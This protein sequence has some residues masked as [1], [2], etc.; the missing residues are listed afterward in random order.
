M[1][2]NSWTLISLFPLYLT[3]IW[4]TLS[5]LRSLDMSVWLNERFLLGCSFS[6]ETHFWETVVQPLLFCFWLE[7]LF[8]NY[9]LIEFEHRGSWWIME[10][11]FCVCILT[12]LIDL[13]I[14]TSY[15]IQI[16]SFTF[17]S[18]THFLLK[19]ISSLRRRALP[20]YFCIGFIAAWWHFSC[21]AQRRLNYAGI[22]GS[23]N[24][25]AFEKLL[26]LLLTIFLII[27]FI[28]TFKFKLTFE[29]R[30]ALWVPIISKK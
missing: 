1:V 17:V 15:V 29:W 10:N 13:L 9:L 5:I 11:A 7:E 2:C 14:F 12:I 8:V 6:I 21:R 16:A 20:R 27:I 25:T 22:F 28:A 30:N 3:F 19:D 26:L 23:V 4:L 18:R 24:L